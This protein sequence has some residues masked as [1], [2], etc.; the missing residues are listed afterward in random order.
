MLL[1]YSLNFEGQ[2]FVILIFVPSANKI[3]FDGS[4]I[5]FGKSLINIKKNKGPSTGPWGTLF[6]FAPF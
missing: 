6:Y 2:E 4:A 3:V 1:V 5:I